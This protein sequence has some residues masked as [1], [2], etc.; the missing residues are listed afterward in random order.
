MPVAFAA[1]AIL[2]VVGWL[3][4]VT[5]VLEVEPWFAMLDRFDHASTFGVEIEEFDASIV[6]FSIWRES[7]HLQN[8]SDPLMCNVSM[9]GERAGFWD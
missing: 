1:L 5:N 7:R 6:A 2:Y 8:N 4:V 9:F 3:D